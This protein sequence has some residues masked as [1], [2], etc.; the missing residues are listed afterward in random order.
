ML[1]QMDFQ[2]NLYGKGSLEIGIEIQVKSNA[3][4]TY[5]TLI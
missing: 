2:I 3:A 1:H 4:N 5:Y